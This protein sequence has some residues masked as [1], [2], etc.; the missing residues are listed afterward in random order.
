MAAHPYTCERCGRAKV[1]TIAGCP[2]DCAT[3]CMT[4][5]R[6]YHVID[7]ERGVLFCRRCKVSF[8][9]GAV[10]Q[11]EQLNAFNHERT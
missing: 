4:C 9:A 3:V 2:G 8:V 6:T 5:A 1:C 11:H 7:T 10:R